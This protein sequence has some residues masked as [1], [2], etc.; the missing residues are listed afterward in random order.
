MK[1]LLKTTLA[2]FSVCAL[3]TAV[4]FV[5]FQNDIFGPPNDTDGD[6]K[7]NDIDQMMIMMECQM[8]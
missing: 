4:L 1:T 5:G 3:V 2:I 8:I 7:S 6:G